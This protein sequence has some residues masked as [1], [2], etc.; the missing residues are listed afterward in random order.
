MKNKTILLIG[1]G[2]IGQRYIEAIY[3]TNFFK[4]IYL[5]D[6][7][8]DQIN[9]IKRKLKKNNSNSNLY[10]LDNLKKLPNSIDMLIL[11]NT[12]TN[13]LKI[14]KNILIKTKIKFAILEK[15]LGQS[16]YQLNEF[17][18]I[19]NKYNNFYVN[20]LKKNENIFIY[21]KKK[22]KKLILKKIYLKGF[23]WDLC[24][25]AVHYIDLFEDIVNQKVNSIDF[26]KEGRWFKSKRKGYLECNGKLNIFF[27]KKV[28]SY[29]ECSKKNKKNLLL[30]EF[31]KNKKI[32]IDLD[33][34]IYVI[35]KIK[36]KFK[37]EYLSKMMPN[38]IKNTFLFKSNGLTSLT[39]SSRQHKKFLNALIKNFNARRNIKIL[40]I[41]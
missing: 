9:I 11:S 29:I 40:P 30:L 14:L 32:L 28:V 18:K 16:L 24:C 15:V 20:T 25:N 33:K 19:G 7:E 2:S 1:L 6:K 27:K 8:I 4:K 23:N 21:L 13:R 35:D 41:T 5:Y 39:N 34:N 12:S 38:I 26:N 3:K 17:E 37:Q 36:K 10:F 22:I 31:Q